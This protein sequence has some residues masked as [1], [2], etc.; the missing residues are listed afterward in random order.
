M[1]DINYGAITEALNNKV[2][3]DGGNAI[4][5]AGTQFRNISKWSNVITNCFSELPQNIKL[6]LNTSNGYLTLKAGSRL[7]APNGFEQ[8]GTTPKFDVITLDS[9]IVRDTAFGNTSIQSVLMTDGSILYQSPFANTTSG[10]TPL[11]N[12]TFYNTS[13][14]TIKQYASGSVTISK[15][16]FPI[17]IIT[18]NASGFTA[19]IDH[20]FNNFGYIGSTAFVLPGIKGICP[21][22][23]NSDG[24]LNNTSF[25]I[26]S[27]I[28]RTW[29]YQSSNQPLFI[30]SAQELPNA[31]YYYESNV[32]PV[33][34][35][36]HYVIW[37]NPDDNLIRY[38]GTDDKWTVQ[39]TPW[40]FTGIYTST[41]TSTN[42]YK[43]TQFTKP[44]TVFDLANLNVGMGAAP[45][46]SRITTVSSGYTATK[47]GYFQWNITINNN[48]THTCYVNN[49]IVGG[50]DA[51]YGYTSANLGTVVRCSAGDVL[52]F[53][54]GTGRFMP[55]K[56]IA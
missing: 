30:T 41:D 7:Y 45:D 28:V 37:Y 34:P 29:T 44:K 3:L 32:Q 15:V 18:I 33:A 43:I 12:G 23:R 36:T 55:C 40:L 5:S 27:V 14:N 31:A 38:S 47:D 24:T 6:E 2:D 25:S 54:G 13:N 49:Y 51:D 1:S 11:T 35:T 4:A 21:N 20:I 19:S 17:A 42:N 50:G 48:T 10:T 46:W 8:D 39:T 9:D 26:S 22:G 16:C 56:G 52:T 53:T